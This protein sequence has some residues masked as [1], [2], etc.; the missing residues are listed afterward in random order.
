MA[1][2]DALAALRALDRLME[3]EKKHGMLIEAQH[4]RLEQLAERV[5]R[6]ESREEV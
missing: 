5:Q 6:L 3:L 2:K 1:L 4:R